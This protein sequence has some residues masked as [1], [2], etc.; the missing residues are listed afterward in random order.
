[1]RLFS[2]HSILSIKLIVKSELKIDKI[3]P[4]SGVEL[5]FFSAKN[6]DKVINIASLRLYRGFIHRAI[7]AMDI[8]HGNK[9]LDLDAAPSVM[10]VFLL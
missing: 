1:L 2:Y 9:I 3:Y 10:H 5:K 8:Q 7:K 6:Y 4:D